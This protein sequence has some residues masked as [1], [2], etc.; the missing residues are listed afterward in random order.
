MN[1][2]VLLKAVPVVGTERLGEGNLTDRSAQLEAN[3]NDEYMLE[4]A[5]KLTEAHGGEV[6]LLTMGPASGTDALRKALAM[7]AARAVHVADDALRGS[8][9]RA[10]L[11]VLVAALQ[12]LEFDLVFAG[13]DTSDGQGGLIGAALGVRLGLPYLS[14]AQEIEPT[15]GGVRIHRISTSG[16]DVLEAPTPAV[17][18]GTQLLGEPRYPSLRGIMQARSKPIETWS[19]ADLGIEAGSVGAGAATNKVVGS[20][21][22]PERGGATFVRE[23]ADVAVAQIVDFLNQRRLI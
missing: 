19:L 23:S 21:K 4:K 2:V 22:P 12:K 8:D 20:E 1:I 5:L 11:D 13:A 9:M 10:T 16:Y 17:V 14:Y 3:G 18:M 15:D 6:T 7:G